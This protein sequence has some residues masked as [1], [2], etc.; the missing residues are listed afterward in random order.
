M[1]KNADVIARSFL[2]ERLGYFLRDYEVDDAG[3]P[4]A[5][6]VRAGTDLRPG[7]TL[8]VREQIASRMNPGEVRTSKLG[9]IKID[10]IEDGDAIAS[11]VEGKEKIGAVLKKKNAS[12]SINIPQS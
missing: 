12:I 10:R 9:T 11:L 1:R 6:V 2:A 4:S 7:A 3:N 8:E 5:L